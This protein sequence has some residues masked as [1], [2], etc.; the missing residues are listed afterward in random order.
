[1]RLADK[2]W[3]GE[4]KFC[5]VKVQRK[6]KWIVAPWINA[7][8]DALYA[9]VKRLHLRV[10]H[11]DPQ[12]IAFDAKID[13]RVGSITARPAPDREFIYEW[14]LLGREQGRAQ[15]QKY[16]QTFHG[17]QVHKNASNDK[18]N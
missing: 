12:A 2:A 1:M 14:L 10:E 5:S 15:E 18:L 7:R 8:I 6:E 16:R 9:R 11:V 4:E 3:M 13:C 17:G